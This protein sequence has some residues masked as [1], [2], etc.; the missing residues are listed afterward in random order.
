[1]G[2]QQENH[3]PSESDPDISETGGL[4]WKELK[5]DMLSEFGK[6]PNHSYSTVE[7]FNLLQSLC[8]GKGE[9]SSIFLLRVLM[10]VNILE[11]KTGLEHERRNSNA[12]PDHN[13][14]KQNSHGDAANMTPGSSSSRTTSSSHQQHPLNFQNSP[15]TTTH[16]I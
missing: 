4:S 3:L 6:P 16:N 1:M 15:S 8:K 14:S 12:V 13:L 10:V 5:C 7:K 11:N 9:P 2:K